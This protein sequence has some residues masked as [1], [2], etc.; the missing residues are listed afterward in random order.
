MILNLLITPVMLADLSIFFYL[1]FGIVC[2]DHVAFINL[3][4]K[5]VEMCKKKKCRIILCQQMPSCKLK[6]RAWNPP[7]RITISHLEGLDLSRHAQL[8]HFAFLVKGHAGEVVMRHGLIFVLFLQSHYITL[9]G[10]EDI[11]LVAM[12]LNFI[13]VKREV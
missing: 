11:V 4:Y 9:A 3:I 7:L 13:R 2:V 12:F 5:F 6:G 10:F 1:L 8:D